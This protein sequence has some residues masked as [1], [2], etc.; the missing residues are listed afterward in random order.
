MEKEYTPNEQAAIE[1][2]EAARGKQAT[3]T[4]AARHALAS[5]IPSARTP[6]F[7]LAL[8]HGTLRLTHDKRV[9]L[10]AKVRPTRRVILSAD[11]IMERPRRPQGGGS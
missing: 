11:D 10:A 8:S 2:F 3:V 1:R 6:E 4:D 7:V 9:V 5:M